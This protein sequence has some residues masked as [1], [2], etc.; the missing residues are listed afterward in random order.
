MND[1]YDKEHEEE[2][3]DYDAH[4]LEHQTPPVELYLAFTEELALLRAI[5]RATA[6]AIALSRQVSHTANFPK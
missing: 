4:Y 2:K 6:S 5:E 3:P 1:L